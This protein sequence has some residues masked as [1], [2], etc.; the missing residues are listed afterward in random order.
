[1]DYTEYL[2]RLPK[3]ELHCHVEGTLRPATV[4][5]LA[6]KHDIPLPTDDVGHDLRLRD[7]LRV[8]ADLPVRE[9][10]GDRPGGLRRVAYESLEDGVSLG[11]LKY[12]EMFFN[13]TLHTTRAAS[14]GDDHR[15]ARRRHPRRGGR[16]SA[17]AAGSSPT[18]TG[19]TRPRWRCR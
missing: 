8:P 5:D 17:C 1:M 3:V 12:R 16:S 9:L 19:R 11:N 13:P 7:D 6:R 10:D 14:D 4:A 2:R 15:R 18:S